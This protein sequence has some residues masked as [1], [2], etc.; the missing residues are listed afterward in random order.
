MAVLQPLKVTITNY[1]NSEGEWLS[2]V[3]HPQNDALGARDLHFGPELYI[4]R[5]DFA[6]EPP[7]KF[8]RLSPGAMVRL[9]YGYII[10]C[11]EVVKSDS[12]EVI[13]LRCTYVPESKSGRDTSGLKPKGVVHW[14]SAQEGVTQKVRVFGLL[15]NSPN[16]D[17]DNLTAELNRDSL[18]VHEAVVEPALVASEHE[19]F[20]FERVGYFCKDTVDQGAYNQIVTL[21]ATYKPPA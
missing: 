13:E 7:K 4:E 11:D 1:P 17:K 19:R 2:G 9:R 21:R 6:E 16:P 15:F 8:K 20:Q 10:Q 14:V 12:G 18:T 3:W 5:E